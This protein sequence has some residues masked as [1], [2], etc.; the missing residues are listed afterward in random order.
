[1]PFLFH[2]IVQSP[3]ENAMFLF[4]IIALVHLH[5][6]KMEDMKYLIQESSIE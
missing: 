6:N 5:N 2:A 4:G 1:M 3:E